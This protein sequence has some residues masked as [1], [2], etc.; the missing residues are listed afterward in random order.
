VKITVGPPFFNKVNTPLGLMLLF[1]MGVGPVIAWRRATWSALRRSFA[2]P[3]ACGLVAGLVCVA[4]GMRS[5]WALLSFSLVFFVLGT[6]TQEFYRGVR[7]RQ[8]MVGEGAVR[9]LARLVGKNRRRYGGYVIHVAVVMIFVAITGTSVFRIEKQVT[10]NQ[11]E[12][13]EIGGYTLRYEGLEEKETPH[14]A[15]LM[16][17]LA[18]LVDGRQVDTLRPEKRFY[19]KPEQPTTEVAIR[20]TLG[21]DLYLVLGSYDAESRMATILA[22]LNPLIAFLYWGGITLVLGTLVAIWPAPVAARAPAY[23]PSAADETARP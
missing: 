4:A 19:K 18:V 5:F 8:A 6:V 17:R 13:F 23:A 15:Y 1:L 12:T 7:A 3:V 20:S 11:G 2:W 16:A 22:Y 14:V 10:L 21:S 9:A